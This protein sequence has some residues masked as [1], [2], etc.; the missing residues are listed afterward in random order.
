MTYGP[1]LVLAILTLI[2]GLWIINRIVGLAKRTMEAR[3]VEPTLARFLT[4]LSSVGLKLLLLISVAGMVGIQTTSFIAVLGAAGLA[5]GLALQGSLAN[6]A[7]GVLI[8]LFKPF[9]VG[10]V[11]DTGGALG[12]VDEIGILNTILKTFDNKTIIIPNGNL[13]NNQIVNMSLEENRRVDWVFGVGYDDDLKKVK[14]VLQ[15][16]LDA[17]ERILKDPATTI[18]L[19]EFGESSINF[20]VRAW[21][22]AGDLWPV[23]WDMNEK[24]KAAFDEHGISIPFPQRDVHLHNTAV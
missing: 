4:S 15:G 22:K 19:N 20:V 16:L 21:T 3:K 13:A 12:T 23:Y 7:G 24:V 6:F 8:L 18:A 9:R 10:H 11:I 14:E 1:K 5:I 17:E 2:I